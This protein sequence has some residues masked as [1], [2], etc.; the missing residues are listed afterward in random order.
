M[1]LHAIRR[2]NWPG[3]LGAAAICC[4]LWFAACLSGSLL[5]DS[6]VFAQEAALDPL[7]EG[8]GRETV[9]AT[10]AVCHDIDT[11]IGKHRTRD[12]WQD[13]I[14]AMINRGAMGSADDFKAV[15]GYL[16]T[17]FGLVNVNKAVA[18]EIADVLEIPLEQAEAIVRLRT[19]QGDFSALDALKMVPGVDG[20]VIEKRKD[21]IAFK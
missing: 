7:P 16:S 10:C 3:A 4:A 9:K 6:T 8:P 21:R 17:A 18:K 5:G 13:M 14:N 12:E 2:A 19:Q 1:R 11:A 15:I 20:S